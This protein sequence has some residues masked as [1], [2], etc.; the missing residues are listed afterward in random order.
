MAFIKEIEVRWSDLDAN[1]HVTH[2]A[3]ATFAT[4][5]R[6]SWMGQ[7]GFSI[8]KLLALGLHGVLLKEQV[9]YYREVF[10]GEKVT[11]KIHYAGTSLDHAR[12]KFIHEIYKSNGK[13]AAVDTVY[14]AWLDGTS[15]KMAT[16]PQGFLDA[17]DTVEKT[18]DFEIIGH[19]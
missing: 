16:P 13:L 8:E 19:K 1:G 6:V 17:L 10:L 14:G 12:W 18:S 5:T 3:Y 7:I 15:R 9:E 2:T 4:H 11:V